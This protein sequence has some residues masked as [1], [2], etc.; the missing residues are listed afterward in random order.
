MKGYI[1]DT[2]GA[3][4]A[5][6]SYELPPDGWYYLMTRRKPNGPYDNLHYCSTRCL[7][8]YV[9]QQPDAPAPLQVIDPIADEL[10]AAT[11]FDEVRRG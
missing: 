3:R 9:E 2:C 5:S 1:C 10:Q 11:E 4:G 7:A 6:G 8:R